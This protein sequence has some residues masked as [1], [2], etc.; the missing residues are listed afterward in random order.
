MSNSRRLIL[1]IL[2]TA[3]SALNGISQESTGKQMTPSMSSDGV[4][5]RRSAK[6]VGLE[7]KKYSPEEFGLALELPGEPSERNFPVPE[8][9]QPDV[10]SARVVYLT[11]DDFYVAVV[12]IVLIKRP[13]LKWLAEELK[14]GISHIDG[15]KNV[16]IT[17]SPKP[18][19]VLMRGTFTSF[20][21]Q[22]DLRSVL[23][24]SGKEVWFVDVQ[25][26]RTKQDAAAFAARIHDSVSIIR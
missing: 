25:T 4:I 2:I 7:W 21:G 18:D 17:L 6:P 1:S 14:D 20:K 19:K 10:L 5:V 8:Q 16:A 3:T 9:L 12:H 24:G 26:L 11:A 15:F 13:D 23:L 22:V